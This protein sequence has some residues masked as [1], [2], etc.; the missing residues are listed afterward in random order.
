MSTRHNKYLCLVIGIFVVSSF[1]TVK[2]QE[3]PPPLPP[4]EMSAPFIFQQEPVPQ[5]DVRQIT[6]EQEQHALQLATLLD[7]ELAEYL[8]EMKIEKP[9][10][11]RR[12]IT[13]I[14]KENSRLERLKKKNPERYEN[15]SKIRTM[16]TKSQLLGRRYRGADD[17]EKAKIKAEITSLLS[18]LFDLRNLDRQEEVKRLEKQLQELKKSIAERGKNKNLII[19]RRLLQLVG[20]K[21][22][23]EW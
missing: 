16:E 3:A 22:Y 21:S 20:E 19:E 23:L 9:E 13:R 7:P 2:A 6:P 12:E 17:S 4:D 14:I 11:Y 1:V 10:R 5:P 15:V 18:E 8:K